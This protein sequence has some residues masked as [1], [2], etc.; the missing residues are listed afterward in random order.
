M[1]NTFCLVA[2]RG[3]TCTDSRCSKNHKVIRCE[4]CKCHLPTASLKGH[5]KGSRH[6]RNVERK[7]LS[8]PGI[9]LAPP[10]RSVPAPSALQ[11]TPLVYTSPRPGGKA[12]NLDAGNAGTSVTGSHEGVSST[13]VPYCTTPLQG[14]TC[15]DSRCQS[16]HDIVQCKPCDL[17]LPA[18]LLS[19]HQSG[20]IH[21]KNVASYG[22]TDP[23][24]SQYSR[25]SQPTPPP[26]PTSPSNSPP[27]WTDSPSI[28]AAGL[29]I[30]VSHEEGL[31]FVAEGTGTTAGY[32]FPS[33]SHTISIENTSSQSNLSVTSMKLT[34]SPKQW[35]EWSGDR[36]QI[37]SHVS[38][39]SFSASLLR[40]S[41][42]TQ[43]W[44]PRKIR[45][46][47]NAPH[48]G[49][50]HAILKITFSD[51]ARPN[52]QGWVVTRELRGRAILPAIGS[53]LG[54]DDD[55]GITIFPYFAL[56]FSVECPRSNELYAM[57]TKDLIITKALPSPSVSF[58]TATVYSPDTSMTE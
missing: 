15:M 37:I 7:G 44:A 28:Q 1:V 32:S 9:P 18:S 58:M 12:S 8:Y 11:P 4:P 26:E 41:V 25:P 39:D 38:P 48:A 57:Q 51:K 49:T 56:E 5:L 20:K 16:R 27:L 3:G 29:P 30:T 40:E 17:S 24:T 45:V 53:S 21:L 47:F 36:I 34:T 50:F 6:R 13:K 46:D 35:C 43:Q 54:D 2:Q 19:Q 22:S 33:I 31:N 10:S 52:D 23:S 55:A 14:D 42:V